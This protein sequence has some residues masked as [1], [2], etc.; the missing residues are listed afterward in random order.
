MKK[1]LI[2]LVILAAVTGCTE[3]VRAKHWGG[4]MTVAIPAGNKYVNASWKSDSSMWYAYRPMR[5]GETPET[6][7]M[8]EEGNFGLV[9]GQVV[10]IESK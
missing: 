7:T 3:N 1:I 10:F 9:K 4:T 5:Q 6:V 2:L 8:K